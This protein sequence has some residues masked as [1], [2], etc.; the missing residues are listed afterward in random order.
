[1]GLSEVRFQGT[2][3][4]VNSP[5][6]ITATPNLTM[7]ED[8]FDTTV[9][10]TVAGVNDQPTFTYPDDNPGG[11]D[12]VFNVTGTSGLV[13][14]V[15]TRF[16]VA[17]PFLRDL[18]IQLIAPNGKSAWIFRRTTT[19][20]LL[21]CDTLGP[22]IITDAAATTMEA[23]AALL[24]FNSTLAS[25]SC[26]AVDDDTAV[27][28]NL[29]FGGTNPNGTWRLRR[30]DARPDDIGTVS[31]ASLTL[32]TASPGKIALQPEPNGHMTLIIAAADPTANYDLMRS[33]DL[34]N[35]TLLQSKI[36]NA[37]GAITHSDTAPPAP[38]AFYR[39]I[40]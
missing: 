33:T 5:P 15:S 22:W 10:F 9:V 1:V 30:V 3:A 4:V 16:T 8:G 24:A 20:P 7:L 28:L 26:Q 2:A 6:T 40:P 25:G 27:S 23:A 36:T 14:T 34:Q 13:K 37:S 12:I 39:Y 35:W 11:R 29:T 17:H 19:N 38:G 31:L 21:N 32:T 18:H